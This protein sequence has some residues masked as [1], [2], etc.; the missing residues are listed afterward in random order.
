MAGIASVA[1]E[2]MKQA[3]SRPSP[4]L[5]SPASGSC[6]SSSA[7]FSPFVSG[8]GVDQGRQHQVGDVVRQRPADQELHR[9]VVDL[10]GVGPVVCCWVWTQ[11]W[12]STSRIAAAT[13]SNCSRGPASSGSTTWSNTSRR[14]YRASSVPV[15]L[16]GPHPYRARRSPR[17]SPSGAG[18]LD[19][20][21]HGAVSSGHDVGLLVRFPS[22]V[23]FA[24]DVEDLGPGPAADRDGEVLGAGQRAV[25]P[26]HRRPGPFDQPVPHRAG[27]D[28]R[29]VVQVPHLEELPDHHRL[30]HR[31]DPAGHDD[32]GVRDEHE[33]VQP[34]EERRCS[35]A[36]LTNG[37]TSCSNGSSTRMPTDARSG[38]A[39]AI[40]A[41]SFAAC[42]SPGPP[43]VTMS[44]P[45][46]VSSAARSRTAA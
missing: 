40:R 16:T 46:R 8:G 4:P 12:E 45:R 13:A 39:P 43:P 3:A 26:Q 32:E 2:S 7:S 22:A 1:S 30:Q 18:G 27:Q 15:N 34:G 24:E 35:N 17:P 11:R 42:I 25:G 14:S 19:G 31:A 5:P 21:R 20:P 23:V 29:R 9:Q 38:S 36:W 44:Q 10:L 6:S 33:V 41:P 37:L 28:Q